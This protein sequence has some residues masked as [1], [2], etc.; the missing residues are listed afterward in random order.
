MS[1]IE[2]VEQA[3]ERLGDDPWNAFLHVEREAALERA[4]RAPEGP[5]AGHVAS[6]KDNLAWAGR[7]MTCGSRHLERYVAPYTATVVARLE[8]AGAIV[9]GKTNMDEFAAGSSGENSAFGATL[10]PRDTARVPGGSSSG[11]GAS[12]ASG[13]C[14]LALGSDTGGSARCPGA[15][16]GVAAFKPSYGLVSRH[17]LAD[18]A[19]SLESPAPLARDVGTL[20]RLLSVISGPDARDTATGLALAPALAPDELLIGVP[21][22]FFEGVAADVERPVRDALRRLEAKGA[23]LVEVALPSVRHS[24]AAYYVTNYAEFASAMARLDGFRYGTP[25]EGRTPREAQSAARASFGAEVKRRILLGTYVTSREE[26]GAWYD[27]AVKARGALAG[28]FERALSGVD[29]LM[30]PTMPMRA[31]KLGERADDP[32]AMYAADVLTVSANL[33]RV[34]AGSVPLDVSGL[35]VGLQVIG[36]HG[37]DARVL[38]AMQ[39]VEAL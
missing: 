35:P 37:D 32:R 25:G 6:V 16:C 1:A 7:P 24:L 2:R 15:F 29:V 30:G 4:R 14:D 31:F 23:T 17:G 18:L 12:V 9:I 19:M 36:R 22:E 20:A 26:R 34:P 28:E 13:V 21:R 33:A 39:A 27:A 8:A 5:L 38:A 10:N 3:F 11:A